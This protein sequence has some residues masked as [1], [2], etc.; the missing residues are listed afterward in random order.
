MKY[1]KKIIFSFIIV[2]MIITFI[3]P[4][5]EFATVIS[6][7]GDLDKYDG[8]GGTSVEFD[9]KV[10]KIVYIVQVVGSIIS[11]IALVAMGIKYMFGS[12]EERAVYKNT[13]MPYA[14]G[15]IMV[16]G[17]SNVTGLLYYI[18]KNMISGYNKNEKLL[19]KFLIKR[20]KIKNK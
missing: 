5:Y 6:G 1:I 16:F 11:V 8:D 19:L 14:I 2:M 20:I 4:K 3:I 18:A 9:K 17:I 7:L 15:A 12:I 10:N 13:M